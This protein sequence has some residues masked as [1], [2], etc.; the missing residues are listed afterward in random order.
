MKKAVKKTKKA[1]KRKVSPYRAV[2]VTS[3][4]GTVFTL[5]KD[6]MVEG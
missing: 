6:R 4:D 5:L 1:S 2:T 3:T